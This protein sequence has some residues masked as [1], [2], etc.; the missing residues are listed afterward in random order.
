MNDVQEHAL[1]LRK[2]ALP[3]CEMLFLWR[4]DPVCRANSMN[5]NLISY[6]EHSK[7]FSGKMASPDCRIYICM[8]GEAAVG[9]VRLDME[10]NTGIVS[11]SVAPECRGRGL[12]CKML[13]MLE[14]AV[15]QEVEKLHAIVKEHN[16]ASRRCFEKLG[17]QRRA[18]AG[19][20]HY[21]KDSAHA[22]T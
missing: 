1:Y 15:P 17:Y 18:G 22:T 11:Y 14:E 19:G 4:N 2:A 10:G 3:D 9:Q 16:I 8:E 20:L 21:W 12:G 7:W 5:D 6:E 13:Q